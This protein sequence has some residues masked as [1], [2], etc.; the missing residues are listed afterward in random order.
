MG[1]V[2]LLAFQ[3]VTHNRPFPRLPD[4]EELHRVDRVIDGDTLLLDSGHTVRLLG[5]NCPETHHP[6]RPIEP[7]GEEATRYAA[8][9][10]E[11]R[12]VRLEFDRE[13]LD[14]YGRVLAYVYVD[15]TLLNESLIEAGLGRAL[16]GFP[17]RRDM[18]A[19]F[20]AAEV[21]ARKQGR[22]LWSHQVVRPAQ[23]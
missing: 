7:Y 6:D 17:I 8:T 14:R 21:R 19:R 23:R 11:S 9:L 4:V 10:V 15:G 22:G 16:H 1:L 20:D 12:Q 2:V 13:R 3:V 5:V 18:L